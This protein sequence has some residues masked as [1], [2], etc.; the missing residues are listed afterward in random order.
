MVCSR[1]Q[2]PW[3]RRECES[4]M[5]HLRFGI[6]PAYGLISTFGR[7]KEDGY[8]L[9]LVSCGRCHV[10]HVLLVE[11]M[12]GVAEEL[13]SSAQPRGLRRAAGEG[14]HL[15]NVG[16]LDAITLDL[17]RGFDDKLFRTQMTGLV[18]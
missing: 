15:T 12:V 3:R 10:I 17:A 8:S 7:T 4:D 16:G 9:T 5:L 2:P 14:S 6:V 11:Q 13:K 1:S 18:P